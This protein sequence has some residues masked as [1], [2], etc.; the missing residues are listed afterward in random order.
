MKPE[1][2]LNHLLCLDSAH[3]ST[4]NYTKSIMEISKIPIK[5]K[6]RRTIR[7]NGNNRLKILIQYHSRKDKHLKK[8]G[9]K[10]SQLHWIPKYRVI[11]LIKCNPI[12]NT[13][14][15]RPFIKKFRVKLVKAMKILSTYWAMSIK[16]VNTLLKEGKSHKHSNKMWSL[17]LTMQI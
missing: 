16:A 5:S 15:S 4:R 10:A 6:N 1:K 14:R 7:R 12:I 17:H 8:S 9:I 13:R 2:Y 11:W 3:I